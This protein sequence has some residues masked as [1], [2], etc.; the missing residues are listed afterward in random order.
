[1][2]KDEFVKAIVKLDS[3][4]TVRDNYRQILV[5]ING[6]IALRVDESSIYTIQLTS[7][8]RGLPLKKHKGFQEIVFTYMATPPE[9]RRKKAEKPDRKNRP[10]K[11]VLEDVDN[12]RDK[13]SS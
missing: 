10:L 5:F 12:G 2:T 8:F 6:K 9:L 11:E 1:M 7:A 13:K 4:I 3:S